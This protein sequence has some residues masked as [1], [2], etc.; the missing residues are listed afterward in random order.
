MTHDVVPYVT[1]G[2]RCATVETQRPSVDGDVHYPSISL[3]WVWYMN[4]NC[5]NRHHP[6]VDVS[7]FNFNFRESLLKS[8]RFY[9]VCS[10][11]VRS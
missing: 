5:V 7:V 6:V 11:F 8:F 10:F 2:S 4:P 9:F 3:E 1:N